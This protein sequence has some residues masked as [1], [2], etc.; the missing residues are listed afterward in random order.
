MVARYGAEIFSNKEND[1]GVTKDCLVRSPASRADGMLGRQSKKEK[2]KPQQRKRRMITDLPHKARSERG[3]FVGI[4]R[5]AELMNDLGSY[6]TA[7]SKGLFHRNEAYS[8]P[9]HWMD[10]G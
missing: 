3:R 9:T 1:K 8:P 10:E 2:A 7:S 5:R 6:D 4:F